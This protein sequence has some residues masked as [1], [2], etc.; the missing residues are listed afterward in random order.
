M[1]SRP[2]SCARR[3]RL[4]TTRK[5]WLIGSRPV[6]VTFVEELP[7]AATASMEVDFAY[8]DPTEPHDC[9]VSEL[10]GFG[11]RASR[12]RRLCPSPA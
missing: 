9:V 1:N 5:P 12:S 11:R 10:V 7:D 8:C 2:T 6:L 4:C 3:R